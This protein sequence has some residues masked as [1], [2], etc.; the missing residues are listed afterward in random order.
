[1]I[2]NIFGLDENESLTG[3]KKQKIGA[4]APTYPTWRAEQNDI[5]TIVHFLRN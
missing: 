3:S 2:K 5:H 4:F 1:M